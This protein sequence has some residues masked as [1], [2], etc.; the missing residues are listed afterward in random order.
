MHFFF[1]EILINVSVSFPIDLFGFISPQVCFVLLFFPFFHQSPLCCFHLHRLG[2]S[3]TSGLT[4]P[5]M[6][7]NDMRPH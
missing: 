4:C 6:L 1:L 5:L 2:L 7:T 3:A